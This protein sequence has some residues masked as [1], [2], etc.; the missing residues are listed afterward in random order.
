MA[1]MRAFSVL[2][3]PKMAKMTPNDLLALNIVFNWTEKEY[4][5]KHSFKFQKFS[6]YIELEQK[7]DFSGNI[8]TYNLEND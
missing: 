8:A 7:N 5:T 4:W 1:P 2:Q 3:W 6:I